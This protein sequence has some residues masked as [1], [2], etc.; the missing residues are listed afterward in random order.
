MTDTKTTQ[1]NISKSL[2]NPI[3]EVVKNEALTE[4]IGSTPAKK[5]ILPNQISP[6]LDKF[7]NSLSKEKE[8]E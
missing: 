4:T 1:E 2:E 8:Q 5:K 7:E 3:L 6:F